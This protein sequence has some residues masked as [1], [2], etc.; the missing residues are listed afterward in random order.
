MAGFW[1]SYPIGLNCYKIYGMFTNVRS[2]LL[3]KGPSAGGNLKVKV[4]CYCGEELVLKMTELA[5][6]SCWVGGTYENDVFPIPEGENLVFVIV[7]GN[8]EAS[9]K[10]KVIHSHARSKN[11]KDISERSDSDTEKI[12]E[13]IADG[14]ATV[15]L[16]SSAVNRQNPTLHYRNGTITMSV[17]IGARFELVDLGIAMKHFGIGVVKREFE[18][19]N[20]GEWNNNS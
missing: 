11:R 10:D 16:A 12:P 20:G 15:K 4:G 18:L 8:I 14:M 1:A 2:M 19:Q 7:F 6:G 3:M 17:D 13:F 5:F 9:I